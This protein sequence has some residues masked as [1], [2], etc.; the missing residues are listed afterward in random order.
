MKGANVS[1]LFSPQMNNA[2]T[3]HQAVF[4]TGVAGE[5]HETVGQHAARQVSVEFVGGE[6][7]QVR[8]CGVVVRR[9]KACVL[10][11]H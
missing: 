4:R 3:F 9:E 8:S 11:Q 7:R 10:L 5:A 2:D 6:A 1:C